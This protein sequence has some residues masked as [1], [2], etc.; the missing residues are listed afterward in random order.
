MPRD[1]PNQGR[2]QR[3][4]M[5][6]EKPSSS[7]HDEPDAEN[8]SLVA[9]GFLEP[10]SD[11]GR[12][13]AC[14]R[15]REYRIEEVTHCRDRRDEQDQRDDDRAA[16]DVERLAVE[17]VELEIEQRQPDPHRGHDLDEHQPQVGADEPQSLE[18][19]RE[20]PDGQGQRGEP[21]TRPAEAQNGC[22]HRGRV[23][24]ANCTD[25][26][27]DTSDH[28]GVH[29]ADHSQGDTAS[30]RAGEARPGPRTAVRT[31]PRPWSA[32]GGS[33]SPLRGDAD[34]AGD[35]ARR[36]ALGRVGDCEL[37]HDSRMVVGD[38]R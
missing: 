24:V 16:D 8:H 31:R 33:E 34:A 26:C 3:V 35:G 37:D 6:V 23:A 7:A 19:H 29:K 27:E 13:G 4:T 12:A 9:L 17:R 5:I 32:A 2:P 1:S 28:G 18:Q 11:L 36:P 22:L 30:P 10:G 38:Q 25:E 14:D 20:R 21:T 15:E